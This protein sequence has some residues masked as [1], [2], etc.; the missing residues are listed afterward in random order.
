MF[1]VFRESN[2]ITSQPRNPFDPEPISV[3]PTSNTGFVRP[4]PFTAR[5]GL[6]VLHGL[7]SVTIEQTYELSE[8]K[9]L[10]I[11]LTAKKNTI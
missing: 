10:S 1:K 7:P 5:T 6:D 3:I 11:C 2:I 8:C 4:N 9:F